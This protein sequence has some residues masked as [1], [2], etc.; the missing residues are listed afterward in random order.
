MRQEP[1]FHPACKL[2]E[3]V[4]KDGSRIAVVQGRFYDLTG[5]KATLFSDAVRAASHRRRAREKAW[6]TFSGYGSL[7]ALAMIRPEA[8]GIRAERKRPHWR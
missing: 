5:S 7:I 6:L 1:S 4:D 8:A 2:Q 3:A